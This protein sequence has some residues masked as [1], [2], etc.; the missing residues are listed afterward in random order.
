[1]LR[2]FA[3]VMTVGAM[4]VT[5]YSVLLPAPASAG[6]RKPNHVEVTKV[7]V[8]DSK[9]AGFQVVVEC[10]K[11]EEDN[12]LIL[13]HDSGPETLT[14]GPQ[15]GTETADAPENSTCTIIET[16]D[17]GASKVEVSPSECVF[18]K[19]EQAA[20]AAQIDGD[21]REPCKVTV[22]NTFEPPKPG[23]AGPAG[24]PGPPGEAAAAQAV[25]AQARFTG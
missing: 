4:A 18:P 13:N 20:P 3:S 6:E 21:E 16:H 17:G 23:P 10:K 2:R 12:K 7:V 15:G 24:P 8:G 9:G 5:S 25:T 14:F 19:E 11:N 1:M 22:T